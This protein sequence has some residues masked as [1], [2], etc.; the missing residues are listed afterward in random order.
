M[1]SCAHTDVHLQYVCADMHKYTHV[2]TAHMAL[3]DTLLA[4]K[5]VHF[6]L[7]LT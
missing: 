7:E 3:Q 5:I 6:L 4:V 1:Y 2:Q